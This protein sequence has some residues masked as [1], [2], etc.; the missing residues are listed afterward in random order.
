ME[1]H[2]VTMLTPWKGNPACTLRVRLSLVKCF[3]GCGAAQVNA[4]P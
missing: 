2:L 4:P 3:K 1:K